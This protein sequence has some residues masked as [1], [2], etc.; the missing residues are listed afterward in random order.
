M[1]DHHP[2]VLDA[3]AEGDHHPGDE[4]AVVPG[5]GTNDQ[6][7]GAD[8]SKKCIKNRILDKRTNADIFSFTLFAVRIHKLGI[9]D[10]I[11]DSGHNGDDELNDTNDDDS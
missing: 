5:M 10:N 4:H 7:K 2:D 9:L 6:Q 11:E 3:D 1:S 8:H